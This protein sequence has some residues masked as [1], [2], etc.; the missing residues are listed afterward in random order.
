MNVP[1]R[2]TLTVTIEFDPTAFEQIVGGLE[3]R[4]VA[5]QVASVLVDGP[6]GD[7]I[8]QA[9]TATCNGRQCRV[10]WSDARGDFVTTEAVVA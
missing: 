9:A 7:A 5:L 8:I 4:N 1:T 10:A 3:D 6:H 2:T